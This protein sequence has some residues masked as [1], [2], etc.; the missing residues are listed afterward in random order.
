MKQKGEERIVGE[1]QAEGVSTPLPHRSGAAGS[2]MK[3]PRGPLETPPPPK[4]AK[5]QR[6]LVKATRGHIPEG[7]SKKTSWGNEQ[8]WRQ[9]QERHRLLKVSRIRPPALTAAPPPVRI[10]TG[11]MMCHR[12]AD[13]HVT[14]RPGATGRALLIPLCVWPLDLRRY[15]LM[16]SD[17]GLLKRRF[18]IM[19]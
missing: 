8:K 7:K 14:I 6:G 2:L 12:T 15:L 11:S 13:R 5:S 3:R 9:L 10:S 17:A 19:D 4:C 18:L 16:F 1:G